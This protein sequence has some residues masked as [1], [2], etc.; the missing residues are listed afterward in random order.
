M[1]RGRNGCV[2]VVD[3]EE[4]VASS[5]V[6]AASRHAPAF[7]A[8]SLH[9]ALAMSR[10]PGKKWIAAI[11]DVGLPDGS[12]LDL[13][14][15]LR[16]HLPGLP[17]LVMTG[18]EE[19]HIANEAQAG[20]AYFA[21]KPIGIAD[22]DA[23]MRR[24]ITALPRSKVA[25]ALDALARSADLSIRETEIL[26]LTLEGLS[27]AALRERF[28]VKDSTLKTQIRSILTKCGE[29][30]LDALVQRILGAAVGR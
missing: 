16:E 18:R 1:G 27:R 17:V 22:V 19:R 3:D 25:A 11:V 21:F 5:V 2:L 6:R 8:A 10:M 15:R 7:R 9:E 29:P 26:E 13:V 23:F 24:V 20:G 12:G 28:D 4:R 14:R 30:D